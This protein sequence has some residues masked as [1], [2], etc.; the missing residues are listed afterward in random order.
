MS[1]PG[2]K[3]FK[4]TGLVYIQTNVPLKVGLF[5][6]PSKKSGKESIIIKKEKKYADKIVLVT[7]GGIILHNTEF[8]RQN[9][10]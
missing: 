10:N 4:A 8:K 7:Y 9:S 1:F 3:C 6:N 2:G 5:F